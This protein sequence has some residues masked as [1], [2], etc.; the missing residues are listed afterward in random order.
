MGGYRNQ[1]F[2][3]KELEWLELTRANIEK[4]VPRNMPGTYFLATSKSKDNIIYI[5]SASQ[6]KTSGVRERLCSYLTASCH[7]KQIK[8]SLKNRILYFMFRY[9]EH[10]K[11]SEA[12]LLQVYKMVS[13]FEQNKFN[14]KNEWKPLDNAF[15]KDTPYATIAETILG[16]IGLGE[17][18]ILS[19]KRI[20]KY[21]ELM[22]RLL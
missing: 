3:E 11:Q 7:N 14:L 15:K 4:Y 5:G 8:E 22:I 19:L 6:C 20:G 1:G 17:E 13:N 12:Y 2:L 10:P 21:Q 18:Q 9:S 16:E